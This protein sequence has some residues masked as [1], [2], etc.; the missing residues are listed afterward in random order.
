M[1]YKV[2]Q[3]EAKMRTRSWQCVLVDPKTMEKFETPQEWL[4]IV[5]EKAPQ[6][7]LSDEW[8]NTLEELQKQYVEKFGKQLSIRYKNDIEWIKSK[9]YS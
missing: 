1:V 4:E 7:V 9:L 5:E 6:E 3:E 8:T 2:S